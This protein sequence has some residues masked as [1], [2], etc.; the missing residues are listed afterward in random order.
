MAEAWIAP[1]KQKPN[2]SMSEP[3]DCRAMG[4]PSK[5]LGIV[6]KGTDQ[7]RGD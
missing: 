7:T 1:K 3:N 6:I 5:H 2:N 4:I